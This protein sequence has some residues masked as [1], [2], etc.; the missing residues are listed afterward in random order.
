MAV[1]KAMRLDPSA[2]V[3]IEGFRVIPSG[4]DLVISFSSGRIIVPRESA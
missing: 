3:E 2:R 4:N 1:I